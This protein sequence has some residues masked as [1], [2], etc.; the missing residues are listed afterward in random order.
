MRVTPTAAAVLKETRSLIGAAPDVGVRLQRESE[1]ES[2]E[3]AVSLEFRAG[4]EPTDTTIDED[5]LR[6]FVADD[7]ADFLEGRTLDVEE[8]SSGVVELIV[9]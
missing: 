7:L 6:I 8:T 5:G 4:C 2:D 1:S 9:R 3:F